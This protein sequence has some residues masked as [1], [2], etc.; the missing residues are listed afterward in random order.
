MLGRAAAGSVRKKPPALFIDSDSGPERN[1]MYC[2]PT[3]SLPHHGRR[4]WLSVGS[5]PLKV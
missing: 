1:R 5:L 2:M 3:S 4:I